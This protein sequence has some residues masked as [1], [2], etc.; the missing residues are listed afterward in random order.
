M[1]VYITQENDNV[2]LIESNI[3]LE[4]KK[5][6][7]TKAINSKMIIDETLHVITVISN[8][9]EF[10]RRWQLM[11][12]FIKRLETLDNVKL[13]V[14]EL[15]YGN[16][17][18]A[19]TSSDNPQHLQLRTEYA[20][21]HKENMINVGVRKLLPHNWKAMAWI[22]G[23]IEFENSNWA[24]ETLKILTKFELVQLFTT[25]FDLDEKNIPMS[26]WQSFGYK[27]CNGEEFKYNRG[28]NYWHTGY[29]WACT[30]EY[31]DRVGGLYENGILGSGDYIMSQGLFGK[32]ACAHSSLVEFKNDI[33]NYV[34]KYK[35]VK[36]G[37]VPGNI[38]HY[39]H[40]S[41]VN[42]K[43]IERNQI[44]VKYKFNP[45]LHIAYNQDGIIIPSEF[46]PME[47]ILDI[48]EYFGQRNED[49]YYELIKQNK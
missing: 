44:L 41:K 27:W 37:Y 36:L 6:L 17:D 1:V 46:M 35:N 28:L 29:A 39:F 24:L 3:I 38:M 20:L 7:V 9:C 49:E 18:F 32:T 13:Y 16:Q 21:W 45:Y 48:Y 33:K 40:G 11:R 5:H 19:V 8:I 23:D 42:R 12:E 30:R 31:F 2:E 15:A 47:F 22:D 10:K 14:V 43:Y 34:K 4:S 26:I 25:C